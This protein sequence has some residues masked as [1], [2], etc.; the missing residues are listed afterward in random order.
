MNVSKANEVVNNALITPATKEKPAVNP[1]TEGYADK[2]AAPTDANLYKAMYN[3]QDKKADKK[4]DEE[5]YKRAMGEYLERWGTPQQ[6][7]DFKTQSA[8]QEQKPKTADDEAY[9][10]A[11]GE[12][13][14]KWGTDKQWKEFHGESSSVSKPE[15][16]VA[17]APKT[18]TAE[19]PAETSKAETRNSDDDAYTRA[20]EEYLEK[21]G[22]PEQI[23]EFKEAQEAKNQPKTE[24]SEEDKEFA[25]QFQE[26]KNK[27]D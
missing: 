18:Q 22:T 3:I 11:M 2:T 16:Q 19:K 27:Y 15:S 21:W 7:K 8:Q 5:A 14:D 23:K 1:S 24:Q 12:Y 13:L 26:F 20:M 25:R 17:N 10:R 6:V 9:Q 4:A